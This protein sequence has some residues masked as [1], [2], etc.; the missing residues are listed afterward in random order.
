L[1]KEQFGH[2]LMTKAKAVVGI[3]M[4]LDG[5]RLAHA[6]IGRIPVCHFLLMNAVALGL[7]HRQFDMVICIQN[8]LSA[9]VDDPNVKDY[10]AI[11]D[12]IYGSN[13]LHLAPDSLANAAQL[14]AFM[15][16]AQKLPEPK[17]PKALAK[18]YG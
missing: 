11:G 13:F 7:R 18:R 17:I 8:G 12:Q 6:L 4:S 5:L 15:A 3:D 1:L 16:E 9:L 2:Q 14:D 10:R